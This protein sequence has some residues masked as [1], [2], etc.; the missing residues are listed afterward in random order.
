MILV[1]DFLQIFYDVPLKELF[2]L[3]FHQLCSFR[4]KNLRIKSDHSSIL[5]RDFFR[6]IFRAM[7]LLSV[8][9]QYRRR[10]P[11]RSIVLTVILS[12]SNRLLWNKPGTWYSQSKSYNAMEWNEWN[13]WF[14]AAPWPWLLTAMMWWVARSSLTAVCPLSQERFPIKCHETSS[15]QPLSSAETVQKQS[16]VNIFWLSSLNY[17]SFN[18]NQII[19]WSSVAQ[20]RLHSVGLWDVGPFKL[21]LKWLPSLNLNLVYLPNKLKETISFQVGI[22][23]VPKWRELPSS[24]PS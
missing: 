5:Y 9:F 15:L 19:S 18:W 11:Y 4:G 13:G 10:T 12:R 2:F 17:R 1:F 20:L 6:I 3:I 14:K 16:R 22:V 23:W 7:F 8:I 24:I 21:R